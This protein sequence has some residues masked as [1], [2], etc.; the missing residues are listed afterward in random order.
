VLEN[1]FCSSPWFHLRLTYSGDFEQC[2][3]MVKQPQ[4]AH[5][6]SSTSIMQ[7]YNSEQMRELRQTLLAGDKP[8]ICSACYYQDNFDKLSG[9]I[10]QLNQSGI[11]VSDFALSARSTPHY[12]HFLFSQN[13]EGNSDYRPIDLQIDLGNIC[14]SACIM[15]DPAASSRLQ[16]DYIKLHSINDKLFAKPI[17]F[18]S[19]TRDPVLVDKFV[20]ELT[21]IPGLRYLHFLGGET[22]YDPAFYDICE[23]LVESG[24]SKS[25][26]VGTTTNGTIYNSRVEK[27]IGEFKQFHLGISIESVT[28]LNDYVR[29]PSDI[30][31]VLSNIDK[32][33]E[34]RNTSDLYISLRITPNVFTASKLDTLFEY[35]IQKNV[36]AESCN[37]L[38]TPAELQ[39]ELMPDDI[40]ASTQEKLKTLIEKYQLEKSNI[41][42]VRRADLIPD[43]V[44]NVV[45]EYKRFIDTYTTP[46]NVEDLRHNLVQYIKSFE[47]IRNNSILD[48]APEYKEF[49]TA[50]GY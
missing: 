18:R 3:Y 9:R 29:Y 8:S 32:F 14:N 33:L 39:I 27:L 38:H 25:I 6:I 12:D 22:L 50:Y 47:Q 19:W 35:M 42:N 49:L 34:L 43:V 2:R 23:R 31:T 37:I 24:L 13:N 41:V 46:D 28:A 7:Y 21:S 1:T 26:I 4:L 36:I 15:C 20:N 48:Y 16:Q 44:A 30:S 11:K 17:E 45:L 10:K 40:R 5:N